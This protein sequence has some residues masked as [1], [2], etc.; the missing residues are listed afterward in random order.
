MKSLKLTA[1]LFGAALFMG[2]G[3]TALYAEGGK[4]GASMSKAATKCGGDKK[5]PMESG[6]KCGASMSKSAP[7][8]GSVMKN[9][10]MKPAPKCGEEKKVPMKSGK[11]G[12]GKCG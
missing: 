7:K 11:C 8:C 6:G 10:P 1:L 12:V 3:T 4:C 2:V 9:A 5:S